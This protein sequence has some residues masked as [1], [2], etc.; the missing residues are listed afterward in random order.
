MV[1][2]SHRCLLAVFHHVYQ[3]SHWTYSSEQPASVSVLIKIAFFWWGEVIE[4]PGG[5]TAER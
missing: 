3:S 1:F 2:L 4:S 5:I